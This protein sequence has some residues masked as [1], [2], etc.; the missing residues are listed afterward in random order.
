MTAENKTK[1]EIQAGDKAGICFYR[2]NKFPE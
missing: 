2:I 1:R